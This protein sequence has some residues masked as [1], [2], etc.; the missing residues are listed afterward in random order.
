[1]SEKKTSSINWQVQAALCEL[2]AL[3]FTYPR[4]ELVEALI[5]GEYTDAVDEISLLLEAEL[6]KEQLDEM[7]IYKGKDS[8]ELLHTLRIEATRLFVGAPDPVVP[9]YEGVWRAQEDGVQPLLFVNPHSMAV[10][11]FMKSCGVGQAEGKNEPLDHVATELEFLEYL[12]GLEAGI[13]EPSPQVD[14]SENGWAEVYERFLEEHP[15][16]WMPQFADAVIAQ[17]RE[18]FY[19]AAASLLKGTIVVANS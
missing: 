16:A 2:L 19:K 3:S 4:E 15:Q 17:T 5:S 12:A 9:P 7:R 1:M 13:I 11:R 18:P 8:K 14:A 10:E 6:P